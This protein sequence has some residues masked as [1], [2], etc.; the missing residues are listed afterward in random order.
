[1]NKQDIIT[2][3]IHPYDKTDNTIKIYSIIYGPK[4][5][6][7]SAVRTLRYSSKERADKV[8]SNYMR[9]FEMLCYQNNNLTPLESLKSKEIELNML[10]E[11]AHF[12][13]TTDEINYLDTTV[14][15]KNTIGNKFYYK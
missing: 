1:M 8:Y 2:D 13:E 5:I 3:G 12:T 9:N 15:T 6:F 10:E 7:K 4:N 11:A 14:R